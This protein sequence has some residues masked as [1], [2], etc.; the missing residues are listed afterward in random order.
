MAGLGRRTHYRKHLTDSVLFDLPEPRKGERIAK[1]MATRGGNQFDIILSS[2]DESSFDEDNE[3]KS[4]LAILPTKFRKL[5]WVKRGDFVIVDT[6][7]DDEKEGDDEEHAGANNADG[8][9][10]IVSHI[11]YKDQIKHLKSKGL[12]PT[13][14]PEFAFGCSDD[15]TGDVENDYKENNQNKSFDYEGKNCDDDDKFGPYTTNSEVTDD[16]IV[17]DSVDNDNDLFV[18]TNRISTLKIEDSSDSSDD[19]G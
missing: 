10:F 12:W 1:V 7:K 19:E 16:G 8:I 5:I 15:I 6:G 13:N 17:Y 2:F 4:H 18:N 9:R 3:R 11:L 14:D